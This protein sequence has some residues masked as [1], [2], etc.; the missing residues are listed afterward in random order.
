M[1]FLHTG[2]DAH[3]SDSNFVF[4]IGT[5]GKLFLIPGSDAHILWDDL[6][7]IPNCDAYVLLINGV[8]TG[9]VQVKCAEV[10][11]EVCWR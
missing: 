6:I 7:L 3:V 10:L 5:H 11:L 9:R 2:I 8:L 4:V 1:I